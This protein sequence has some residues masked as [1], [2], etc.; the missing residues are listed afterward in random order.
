[1]DQ[2]DHFIPHPYV[3]HGKQTGAQNTL[4]FLLN[5]HHWAAD[6]PGLSISSGVLG[7][8]VMPAPQTSFTLRLSG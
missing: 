1:M 7:L 8:G 2:A 6:K 3:D 4:N 5:A